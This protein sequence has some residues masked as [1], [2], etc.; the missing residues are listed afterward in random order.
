M[1]SSRACARAGVSD[2]RGSQWVRSRGRLVLQAVFSGCARAGA[3]VF[4]GCF[5]SLGGLSGFARAGGRLVFS[6]CARAGVSFYRGSPVGGLQGVV[7]GCARAGVSSYRGSSVG[8]LARASR[9]TGGRQ[10]VCSRG[11]VGAER[12]GNA[13]WE[14]DDER[15]RETPPPPP[16]PLA[17][18]PRPS[19]PA[20]VPGW[21]PSPGLA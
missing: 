21:G 18:A 4:A 1:V 20:L 14:V 15:G 13:R 17:R 10:W 5:S 7:S 19:Y 11:R 12:R 2:Y 6:G 16:S 8:V 3:S 9:P